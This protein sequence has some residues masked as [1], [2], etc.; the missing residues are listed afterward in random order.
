MSLIQQLCSKK[1]SPQKAA[2]TTNKIPVPL[3]KLKTGH[4]AAVTELKGSHQFT[5]KLEALGIV[6]N[7]TIVKKS[8]GLMRGP[9]VLVKGSTQIAIGYAM[10]QRVMV[11][12]LD[13]EAQEQ[14]P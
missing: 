14:L 10:A 13:K 5:G 8:T 6:P 1:T 9:V 7:T 2:I 11:I 12:E 3:T 4:T